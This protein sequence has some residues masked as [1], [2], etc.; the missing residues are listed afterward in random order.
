MDHGSVGCLVSADRVVLDC[1]VGAVLHERH[2]LVC[3]C[4]I[5][6]LRSVILED[7][8]HPAAVADRSNKGYQVK[9]WI[10]IPQFHL[11]VISVIFINV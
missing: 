2:V 6:Q 8:E 10:L 7:F 3:C 4:M 9:I 5:D 11:D 1:L